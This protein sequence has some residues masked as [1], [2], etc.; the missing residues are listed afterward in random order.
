[1]AI[2]N[3]ILSKLKS[4]YVTMN[5]AANSHPQKMHPVY[6]NLVETKE[7]C[8]QGLT[9]SNFAKY[10]EIY[11]GLIMAIKQVLY[12]VAGSDTQKIVNLC[13]DLLQHIVTET[14]K[15]EKLKKGD[16]VSALQIFHVGQLGECVAGSL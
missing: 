10:G 13:K 7:L 4:T 8:Q 14:S 1:M 12:G 9:E 2:K 11:D 6:R 16:G 15:E 3:R 5:M